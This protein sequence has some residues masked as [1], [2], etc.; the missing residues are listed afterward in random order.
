MRANAPELFVAAVN[1]LVGT[2][3]TKPGQRSM[4]RCE[5]IVDDALRILMRTTE[6]LADDF[7]DD[8]ELK[9]LVRSEAQALGC[10]FC[11]GRVAPENRRSC[12]WR[13]DGVDRMLQHDD[14]V[15]DTDGER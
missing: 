10:F 14:V 12:F 13:C 11:S 8:T 6:G 9:E 5:R 7:V 2:E 3:L 4:T 15:A 1:E